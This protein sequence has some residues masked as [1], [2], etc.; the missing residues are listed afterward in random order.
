MVPSLG[1]RLSGVH[2]ATLDISEK[3]NAQNEKPGG[4]RHQVSVVTRIPQG[5]PRGQASLGLPPNPATHEGYP[6][7]RRCLASGSIITKTQCSNPQ[8]FTLLTG[9]RTSR[10]TG[11]FD[12]G[13][14]MKTLVA[15]SLAFCLLGSTSAFAYHHHYYHHH[16]YRHHH[17]DRHDRGD[18]HGDRHR[19]GDDHMGGGDH[20]GDDH[21][22]GGDHHDDH[23][24]H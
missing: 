22:G 23:G 11:F 19:H 17:W 12:L 15:A 4:V 14:L 3:S 7:R 18:D 9:Y 20:H 13:A 6:Q 10:K 1:T 8:P 16:Y 21:S 2:I 5:G 24:G